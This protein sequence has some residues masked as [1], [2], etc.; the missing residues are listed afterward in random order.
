MLLIDQEH[1]ETLVFRGALLVLDL[2]MYRTNLCRRYVGIQLSV[3]EI[4][5]KDI[6][7]IE[8]RV[9]LIGERL[10]AKSEMVLP[11]YNPNFYTRVK[12]EEGDW[13]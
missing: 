4:S 11:E 5:Y 12:P 7:G 10:E 1:L 8:W 6:G 2:N 13:K 9:K 3:T